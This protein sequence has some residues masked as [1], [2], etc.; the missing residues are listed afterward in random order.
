MG[1]WLGNGKIGRGQHRSFTKARAFVRG[2]GLK[3]NTEWR[4]YIRSGKKPADIPSNPAQTYAKS[5]WA[6]WGDWLGTGTISSGL[7][8]FRTF[9]KARA[10]VRGLG[11]KSNCE[12]HEYSKSGNRSADIPSNP[13]QAYVKSGWIGMGD[14]LGTNTVAPHLRRYR[15]FKQARAFARGLKLESQT[16]WQDYCNARNRRTL[17]LP[18]IGHTQKTVGPVGAIG[19]GLTTQ[20]TLGNWRWK[21]D[22]RF[23]LGLRAE[24]LYK[25]AL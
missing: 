11:L 20:H 6:G 22:G 23:F 17:P 21:K 4:K 12:W 2:L 18:Q 8:Q 15:S 24:R 10:F 1:D 19:S 14:W 3:S 13:N 5:G 16:E 9:T 25:C 7:R